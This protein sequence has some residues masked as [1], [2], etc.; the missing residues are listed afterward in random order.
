M[1]KDALNGIRAGAEQMIETLIMTGNLSGQAFLKMARASIAAMTAEATVAAIMQL[2]KGFGLLAIGDVAGAKAAFTSAALFKAVKTAAGGAVASA[3]LGAIAPGGASESGG[4]GGRFVTGGTG[5]PET[6]SLIQGQSG[7]RREP[8]V[9]VIRAE[10][11]PG[12]VIRKV[13]ENYRENGE[14]RQLVRQD[15]MAGGTI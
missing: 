1:L 9:I 7:N 11:E 6:I 2:A 10:T 8:Q 12:V 3:A 14:M 13:A 15:I 5:R 4:T